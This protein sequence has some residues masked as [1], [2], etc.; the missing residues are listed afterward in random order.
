MYSQQIVNID[1]KLTIYTGLNDRMRYFI[2][3]AAKYR[4]LQ[5]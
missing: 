3:G 5:H 4:V 2:I 1:G